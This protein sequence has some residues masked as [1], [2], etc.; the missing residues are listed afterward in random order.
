MLVPVVE[1][2]SI[3]VVANR[4]VMFSVSIF[5]KRGAVVAFETV[6]F[7][8][9]ASVLDESRIVSVEPNVPTA[10]VNVSLPE[11]PMIASV[12]VVSDLVRVRNNYL[13]YLNYLQIIGN[14]QCVAY[15][16]P[17]DIGWR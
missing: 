3:P 10:A 2:R 16:M 15:R 9:S 13:F 5:C 17:M 14:Q 11:V 8:T 1:A 12:S 4:P 6:A 7:R